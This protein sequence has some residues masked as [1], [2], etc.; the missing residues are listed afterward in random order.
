MNVK[1]ISLENVF[2]HW[3]HVC[4]FPRYVQTNEYS[5][6]NVCLQGYE[7]F[8]I[9]CPTIHVNY[10][11]MKMYIHIAD[12]DMVCLHLVNLCVNIAIWHAVHWN[13]KS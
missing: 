6:E 3:L 1:K 11:S 13:G 8:Y 2:S 7:F 12:I 5:L 4:G 10:I 9:M